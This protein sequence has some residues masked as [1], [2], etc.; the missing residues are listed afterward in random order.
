MSADLLRKAGA[1]RDV[2]SRAADTARVAAAT[3]ASAA[4]QAEAAAEGAENAWRAAISRLT[5][6]APRSSGEL[7]DEAAYIESLRL[8][9]EKARAAAQAARAEGQRRALA[10]V[11][12]EQ[13]LRKIEL[14]QEGI[15]RAAQREAQRRERFANDE[16]AARRH[17]E[18]APR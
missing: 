13:E 4:T 5:L 10:A 17:R 12:A 3:A 1:V 6:A 2:Y 8:R 16:L 7:A 11:S 9:A 18:R 15:A 14:W